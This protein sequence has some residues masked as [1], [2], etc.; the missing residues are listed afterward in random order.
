LVTHSRCPDRHSDSSFDEVRAQQLHEIHV[1]ATARQL[2]A[3]QHPGRRTRRVRLSCPSRE[4]MAAMQQC[5]LAKDLARRLL[6]VKQVNLFHF[7]VFL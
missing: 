4:R 6:S 3:K 1:I 5:A 7:F 2:V